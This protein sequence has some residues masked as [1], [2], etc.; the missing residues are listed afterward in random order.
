MFK[1]MKKIV[2]IGDTGVELVLE[3]E[4]RGHVVVYFEESNGSYLSW[5]DERKIIAALGF[6]TEP[7][8]EKIEE[9]EGVI[10]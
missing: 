4:A 7:I 6:P 8:E 1:P 3:Q 2:K 5:N 10:E 9:I